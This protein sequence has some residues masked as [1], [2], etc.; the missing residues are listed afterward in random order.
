M[1]RSLVDVIAGALAN[2]RGMRRG[3]P[4]ITNVLDLLPDNLRQEVRDDAEVVIAQLRD[5]G[6]DLTEFERLRE[7]MGREARAH[8]EERQRLRDE[9]DEALALLRRYV[10]YYAAGPFHERK[11]AMDD[12]CVCPIIARINAAL[13]PREPAVVEVKR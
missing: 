12:T 8:S 4:I 3:I 1:K 7:L 6:L 13:A 10:D 2:A 11:C 5:A 9:R